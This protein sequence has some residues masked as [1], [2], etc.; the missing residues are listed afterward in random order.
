[1]T[2]RTS[3]MDIFTIKI[4]KHICINLTENIHTWISP[5]RA[6]SKIKM[7]SLYFLDGKKIAELFW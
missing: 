1:M 3:F 2:D 5:Q 6:L 7:L 4:F